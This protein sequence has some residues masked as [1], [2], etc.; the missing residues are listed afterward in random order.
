[1]KKTILKTL[2]LMVIPTLSVVLIVFG[3][4]GYGFGIIALIC[5]ALAFLDLARIKF[6]DYEVDFMSKKSAL[7]DDER[8]LFEDNYNLVKSFKEECLKDGYVSRKAVGYMLDATENATL[9]L[10]DE[11]VSYLSDYSHKA[12]KAYIFHS[13][14]ENKR[15]KEDCKDIID[16]EYDLMKDFLKMRPSDVYRKYLKVEKHDKD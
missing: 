2:W 10:P 3:K 1:M 6:G 11:I 14:R 4:D 7:T 13:E 15:G 16:A 9:L 12:V 8:K 5:W